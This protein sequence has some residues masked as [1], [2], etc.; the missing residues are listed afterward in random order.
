M[1][2]NEYKFD[3]SRL[4][5]VRRTLKCRKTLVGGVEKSM[6]EGF[7][8]STL[9]NVL[10]LYVARVGIETSIVI[11]GMALVGQSSKEAM[12]KEISCLKQSTTQAQHE[13]AEYMKNTS[14]DRKMS[15]DEL[16]VALEVRHEQEK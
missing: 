10:G 9:S 4:A 11:A 3:R 6:S 2:L 14:E 15:L 13:L 5:V 1:L 12:E 16:R 7:E 8:E